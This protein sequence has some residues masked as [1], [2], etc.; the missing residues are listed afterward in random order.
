MC[1]KCGLTVDVIVAAKHEERHLKQ[2][3][4]LKKKIEKL[5]GI[6]CPSRRSQMMLPTGETV[7]MTG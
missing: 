2:K 7:I 3:K 4:E 6:C 1:F 5:E